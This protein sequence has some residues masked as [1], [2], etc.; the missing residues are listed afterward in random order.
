MKHRIEILWPW[1]MAARFA[2]DYET[3]VCGN[4]EDACICK[5]ADLAE[6]HGECVWYSGVCDDDYMDGE[7]VGAENFIYE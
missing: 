6:Q 2:D 1:K 3:I 4:D 5:I 7:Y